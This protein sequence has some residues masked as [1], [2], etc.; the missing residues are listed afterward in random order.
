MR[1]VASHAGSSHDALDEGRA[2]GRAASR[3]PPAASRHL[4]ACHL[5]D[6]VAA[7]L[8][9]AEAHDF[10]K[11]GRLVLDAWFGGDLV[12]FEAEWR[13]H[14]AYQALVAGRRFACT[15]RKVQRAVRIA[16]LAACL[17]PELSGALTATQF[18]A[19]LT[20]ADPTAQR[21]MAQAHADQARSVR[22]LQRDVKTVRTGR[23]HAA[24][25]RG[26][27]PKDAVQ[28]A[29][30]AV[31]RDLAL[32]LATVDARL[33]ADEDTGSGVSARLAAA[34]AALQTAVVAIQECVPCKP[35]RT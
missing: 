32:L 9:K 15:Q 3:Q 17:G 33:A 20:L 25:R 6:Q 27:P 4:R 14:A 34:G 5:V 2:A 13:E 8:A 11:A 30:D 29:C 31:L 35:R 23:A 7:L 19:L 21:C 18:D 28:A 26:R 22:A 24:P 10:I 12:R 16:A 1:N